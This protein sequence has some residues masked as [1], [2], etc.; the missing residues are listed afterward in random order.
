VNS[1]P[2]G[3]TIADNNTW[4]YPA[5]WGS[6][7]KDRVF[8]FIGY[9]ELLARFRAGLDASAIDLIRREWGFML[10]HGPQQ[11]MWEDIGPWGGGPKNADPSFDHGWSSGA[12][13]ALTSYVLGVRP[14]SPGFATFIVDPHPGKTVTAASG[15]MPTPNGDLTVAWKLVRGKPVV[16]VRAPAGE[17]W[18]NRPARHSTSVSGNAVSPAK[19]SSR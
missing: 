14:T 19:R 1:R 12:A 2:Y 10:T 7:A 5:V 16:T 6:N 8:P 17:R 11:T 9:F 15:T 13:P 3:N 18:A 4:D